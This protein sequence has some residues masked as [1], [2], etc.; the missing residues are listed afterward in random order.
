MALAARRLGTDVMWAGSIIKQGPAI[1]V[2]LDSRRWAVWLL[3]GVG[4]GV[5][6]YGSRFF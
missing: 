3:L 2:S 5:G 1:E 6:R 4:V